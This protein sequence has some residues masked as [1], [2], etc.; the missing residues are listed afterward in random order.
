MSLFQE[1]IT[2]LQYFLVFMPDEGEIWVEMRPEL[3]RELTRKIL[4]M[5]GL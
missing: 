1:Y 2:H 5:I 4:N 3:A